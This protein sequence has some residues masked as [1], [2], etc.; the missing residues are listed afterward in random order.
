M[1]KKT[2]SGSGYTL[3]S[4]FYRS[5]RLMLGLSL[6]S[7]FSIL[8]SGFVIAQTDS[9]VDTG[10]AP[11]ST[12]VKA[13][14]APAP[15]P[16]ASRKP[17][18][19]TII[20]PDTPAPRAN[21]EH[22]APAKPPAPVA[23]KK[24]ASPSR[25]S[26]TA[27]RKPSR[28]RQTA[29][30]AAKKP[31]SQRQTAETA[32]KKPSSQ[33]QT[34]E[35]ARR[36]PPTLQRTA[37]AL[38]PIIAAPKKPILAAPN[39]SIP[40]SET[41][42]KPPKLYISPSQIQE[43][44]QTPD[45]PTNRYLD[46]TEY[47]IG[48]T[49]RDEKPASVVVRDRSTGCRTV[50][51]NGR[52]L[53]GSCGV[54]APNQP[55]ATRQTATRDVTNKPSANRA[56][57]NRQT[58]NLRHLLQEPRLPKVTTQALQLARLT[59]HNDQLNEVTT[60]EPQL[61]G[62][63][64]LPAPAVASTKSV[65]P[66][67]ARLRVRGIRHPQQK[68]Y[69]AYSP[70]PVDLLPASSFSFP[71]ASTSPGS[72]S[73][74]NV[75]R[76]PAGRPNVGNANFMFPLAMPNAITSLFGW[77]IH[78]IAGDYRFH[79]GTDIGAPEGTPVLAAVAG[80]VITADFMGGYGLTVVVQ[81]QDGNNLSLYGHLSEIFVQPGEQV[82]QGNVIGRVGT[83]GYSTGPHLHF[84]WRHL[85]PNGWVALDARP[86]IEYALGQFIKSLQVAQATPESVP[87]R[88]Y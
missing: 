74:Y 1:T 46:R 9:L 82:E 21:R 75:T 12:S 2:A 11:P 18:V 43:S 57:A 60:P 80:Q 51:Q 30:T 48:A 23:A 52:L 42:A 78:P 67:S 86:N 29:E 15:E 8:S 7:G 63:K 13:A 26:E 3:L 61:L 32:A 76:R 14:P 68:T 58:D 5:P 17:V 6:L 33:R 41:V 40:D 4:F 73:Y 70:R 88:G 24:P 38:G 64:R 87:Q 31:S 83:T 54:A 50:S 35:T 62:V 72:Q 69:S 56:I 79:A 71:E 27:T 55:I 28:Q 37:D 81:H 53:S 25:T 20:V 85:T 65:N 22:V 49:P 45:L 10:T 47:N 36:K 66:R 59:A 16:P 39:L 77:R 44:A 34:A 19:T 84:E